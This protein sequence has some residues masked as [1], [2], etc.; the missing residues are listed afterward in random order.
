MRQIIDGKLY[1]TETAECIGDWYSGHSFNDFRYEEASLY[2]TKKGQFFLYEYGGPMT[3]M[4]TQY[5]DSYGSGEG[6]RLLDE[7]E[8]QEWVLEH[9]STS[10]YLKYWEC[11][12]G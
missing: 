12:E 7:S 1:N 4:A 9:L 2:R 5:G 10:V 3:D 11:E 6:L 8:A